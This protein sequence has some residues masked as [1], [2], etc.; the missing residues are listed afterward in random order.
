MNKILQLKVIHI[1]ASFVLVLLL[2]AIGILSKNQEHIKANEE[3]VKGRITITSDIEWFDKNAKDLSTEMPEVSDSTPTDVGNDSNMSIT[4]K[5]ESA[6]TPHPITPQ[7]PNQTTITVPVNSS[8]SQ[9]NYSSLSG[10]NLKIEEG[11][12]FNPV[13][14]LQIKA[15]DK[16]GTDITHKVKFSGVV[17]VNRSGVYSIVARVKLS[18]NREL[19]QTFYVEVLAKPLKVNVTNIQIAQ[20][21][22]ELGENLILKFNVKASNQTASPVAA[23]VNG[24]KYPINKLSKNQFMVEFPGMTVGGKQTITLNSIEMNDGTTI[25]VNKKQEI[26]VLKSLPTLT[27]TIEKVNP[28]TGVIEVGFQVVDDQ[29]AINRK[30]SMIIALYDQEGN[31]VYNV[32]HHVDTLAHFIVKV[33]KNGEYTLKVL[34]YINRD[35]TNAYELMQLYEEPL[36]ITQIDK[37]TLTGN[38]VSIKEGQSFDPVKDLQLKATNEDGDDIT[39]TIQVEHSVN[40]QV[41]GTYEVTAT[42]TKNN[43]EVMSQVYNVEVIAVKTELKINRFEAIQTDINT[44]SSITV[45]LEVELS[46]DY[47]QL[48]SVEIDGNDYVVQKVNNH[49]YEVTLPARQTSGQYELHLSKVTLSNQEEIAVNQSCRVTIA[50]TVTYSEPIGLMLTEE[51]R[52]RQST[53]SRATQGQVTGSDLGTYS[54]ELNLEGTVLNANNQ[55]PEGQLN[56]TLPTTISFVVNTDSDL[57][58]ASQNFEIV[59]NSSCNIDVK[60]SQFIDTTPTE[61]QGITI[62]DTSGLT[63]K[64]RSYVNLTL[65]TQGGVSGKQV[66]LLSSGFTSQE[67]G[68]IVAGATTG[69]TLVGQAGTEA[70]QGNTGNGL[71]DDF[72][73]TFTVSKN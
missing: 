58:T 13:T 1:V 25:L 68:T 28:Q 26:T 65:L 16:N 50:H 53:L 29:L 62:V 55:A 56:V 60:V 46:K 31:E 67:L 41:P 70:D 42:I 34:G 11:S 39:S 52:M 45:Q 30:K 37:S 8:T 19:L 61:G 3:L 51:S 18:D 21:S 15:T 33:P 71:Q 57:T 73:L 20:Q 22:V 14:D 59:N 32:S 9:I 36:I 7:K 6:P 5:G 23:I 43:G 2:L 4:S 69:L 10:V 64:D 17:D 38:N 66:Q 54:S 44:G 27:K 12:S 48:N 72:T 35:Y 40:T 47:L 24:I 49:I 63:G